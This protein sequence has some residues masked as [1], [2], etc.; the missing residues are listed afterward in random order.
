MGLPE[1]AQ[2]QAR[3]LVLYVYCLIQEINKSYVTK[4]LIDGKGVK[5]LQET[6]IAIGFPRA[7]AAVFDTWRKKQEASAAKA[8]EPEA[9]DKKDD[10]KGKKDDKKDDK[11]S[12]KDEK[13]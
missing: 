6:L 7:A 11:K 12:K 3:S 2:P 9:A 13:D 4:G 5:L 1:T 8:E 10:K